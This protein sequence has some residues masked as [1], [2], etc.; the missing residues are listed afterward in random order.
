[1]KT[2]HSLFIELFSG[3]MAFH[4][5][6]AMC[7]IEDFINLEQGSQV[8]VALCQRALVSCILLGFCRECHCGLSVLFTKD[9]GSV[10]LNTVPYRIRIERKEERSSDFSKSSMPSILFSGLTTFP[11]E[12]CGLD[13]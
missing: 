2:V 10:Y 13:P 9:M 11:L 1:M 8:Q 12:G 4:C 6:Y 5:V 3:A 7:G